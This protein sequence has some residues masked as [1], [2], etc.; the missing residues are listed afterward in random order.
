[1]TDVATASVQY[2]YRCVYDGCGHNVSAPRIRC[3]VHSMKEDWDRELGEPVF[4]A[5][6]QITYRR[7][8]MRRGWQSER[9]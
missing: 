4:E 5:N 3:A 8:R 6:F 7:A 2:V 1:M 9:N